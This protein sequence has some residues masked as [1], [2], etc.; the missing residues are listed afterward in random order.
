MFDSQ[1]LAFITSLG[2]NV[3]MG[4][5]HQ[6]IGCNLRAVSFNTDIFLINKRGF[7]ALPKSMQFIVM[8]L[9][10]RIGRTCRVLVEGI[11]IHHI[12][13]NAMGR[14]GMMLYLQ[15]LRHIRSKD[16]VTNV[17]DTEEAKMETGY[18]DNLQSALQPLGDNLEFSTYEVVST[19]IWGGT[20]Q[21]STESYSTVQIDTFS[22][23]YFFHYFR[24]LKKIQ[25]SMQD[26]KRQSKSL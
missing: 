18:L 7:P 24:S 20:V 12:Q 16:E 23:I 1:S 13:D 14:S 4:L 21:Y 11:P 26:I 8:E 2:L 17:I 25:S 10:K 22:S 15:Y 9:L 19:K 6:F 5:L 3:A